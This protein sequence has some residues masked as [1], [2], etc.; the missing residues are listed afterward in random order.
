MMMFGQI[1][2]AIFAHHRRIPSRDAP[3]PLSTCEF[4]ENTPIGE[5]FPE[6]S[7]LD[8]GTPQLIRDR[9]E[10]IAQHGPASGLHEDLGGHARNELLSAQPSTLF[11]R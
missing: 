8:K 3:S 6:R 2:A 10:E 4:A 7:L 5:F 11:L 1:A 9:F